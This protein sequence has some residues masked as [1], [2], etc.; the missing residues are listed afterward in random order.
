MSQGGFISPVGEEE[1][2]AENTLA[3]NAVI[4]GDGG[5]R[6]VQDSG[7][8]IDDSD[9][10]SGVETLTATS[11]SAGSASLTTPLPIASGGT[12]A[13]TATE[14]F[15]SLS[16]TTTKGDIIV[17][18]GSDNIR[19]AIGANDTVLTA[20]S[21]QTSG[22]KW[23]AA[24]GGASVPF[25]QG[26]IMDTSTWFYLGWSYLSSIASV[27]VTT[28][29]LTLSPLCIPEDITLTKLH[30]NCVSAGN[31]GSIARIG[32]YTL[33]T[34]NAQW[35]LL[36]DAGTV[37]I[38]ST[39]VKTATLSQAMT[40]GTPYWTAVVADEKGG[41]A[42]LSGS[43]FPGFIALTSAFAAIEQVFKNSIDA[44]IALPAS[45]TQASVST[46]AT[47]NVPIVAFGIN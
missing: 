2:T 19:E 24:S 40:A 39:G 20:D 3:D 44:D 38:S 45:I 9:N 41:A 14:A 35:D 46:T 10:I 32:I 6:G 5:E 36:V 22:V 29:Q 33:D 27:S 15:D 18:N 37:D 11:V 17:S 30:I 4:R 26:G 43:T 31:P 8:L 42:Q 13:N 7:V 16:P 23:A 21:T 1:L 25:P 12:A 34:V 47:G 28:D